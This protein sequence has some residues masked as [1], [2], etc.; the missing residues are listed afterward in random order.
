MVDC[1]VY[2]DVN[3]FIYWLGGHPEY[4]RVAYEWIKEIEKAEKSKKKNFATSSLTLYEAI[5][6]MAGLTGVNM[7]D[8]KLINTVINS[9]SKIQGLRIEP[10]KVEDF[11]KA[12]ELM[13]EHKLDYEDALHLATAVRIGAKEIISNDKDFDSTPLRRIL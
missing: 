5:V 6:I 2:V 10:L 7:A 12:A 11:T 1:A 4:G 8:E 3:I 9:I 13:K